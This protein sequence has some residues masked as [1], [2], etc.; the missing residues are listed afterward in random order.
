MAIV[1]VRVETKKDRTERV[2]AEWICECVAYLYKEGIY[3][4]SVFDEVMMA[5]DFAEI[6]YEGNMEDDGS[7]DKD[8][9][10]PT[11]V[12]EELSYW[13]E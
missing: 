7:I 6:A 11:A 2:R 1:S 12:A 5:L 9:D 8:C 13:S 4:C 3:D 10:V